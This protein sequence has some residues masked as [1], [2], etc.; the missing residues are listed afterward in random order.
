MARYLTFVVEI[1][2]CL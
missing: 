2:G 1:T